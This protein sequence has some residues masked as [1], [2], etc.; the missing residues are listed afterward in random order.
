MLNIYDGTFL[1]KQ[2]RARIFKGT[3]S[4]LRHFLGTESPLKMM[5][6]SFYFTLK[7]RF[8]LKL[9]FCLDFLVLYKNG[10]IQKIRLISKF[11]T[12]HPGQQIQYILPNI[13]RNKRNQTMKFVQPIEYNM[14][15][16]FVEKSCT[17]CGGKT[18][19][20]SFSKKSKLNVSLDQQS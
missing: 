13:S 3:V 20:R 4:G 19:P 6:N 5:R 11:M 16:I 17:K 2:L 8:L 18:I 12:S 14:R 15:N 7:A 10:L 1:R 9:S